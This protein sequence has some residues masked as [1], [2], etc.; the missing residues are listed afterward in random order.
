MPCQ[1][2][3]E[4]CPCTCLASQLRL[5]ALYMWLLEHERT[6]N[7]DWATPGQVHN[8]CNRPHAPF[9]SA[10]KLCGAQSATWTRR[11]T[12]EPDLA[13]FPPGVWLVTGVSQKVGILSA[14]QSTLC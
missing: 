4:R 11:A 14:Q 13:S 3:E 5:C 6:T 9:P 8:D 12:Y 10:Q 2:P 1:L 7:D